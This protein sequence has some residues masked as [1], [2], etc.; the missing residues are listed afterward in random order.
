M[1]S[2]T[3]LRM[4]GAAGGALLVTGLVAAPALAEDYPPAD[5]SSNSGTAATTTQTGS[6]G[7]SSASETPAYTGAATTLGLTAAVVALGAG[8][9]LLIASR[10]RRTD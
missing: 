5:P 4:I 2:N 10:R 7:G 3:T 8:T 1:D 6:T 9:G